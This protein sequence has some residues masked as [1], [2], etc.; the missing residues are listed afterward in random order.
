MYSIDKRLPR[1]GIEKKIVNIEFPHFQLFQTLDEEY[2]W[3]WHVTGKSQYRFLLKMLI[4]P[5]FPDEQPKLFVVDPQKI[6]KYG[7][8]TINEL[9]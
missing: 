4:P 1:L 8:G 7:S 9:Q 5:N 3:G 6:I 2:I